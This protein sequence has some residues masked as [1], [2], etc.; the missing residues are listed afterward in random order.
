VTVTPDA[1]A[2]KPGAPRATILLALLAVY[3]IWGSTYLGL[4]YVVEE[5]PPLLSAAARFL[6]AG[7]IMLLVCLLLKKPM[8]TRREWAWSLVIGTLMGLC[9]NGF[10]AI[11][12]KDISSGGAAVVCASMP[13]FA[14][15]LGAFLGAK[16]TRREVVGL[17]IGFIG[18]A[19]MC[20][21]GLSGPPLS[22]ALLLSAPSCWALGSLLAKKHFRSGT[23]TAGAQLLSG[24]GMLAVVGALH[25]EQWPE[26][27][28]ARA[29]WALVYL[30][31]VGSLVGFTAYAY[32]L[33]HTRAAVAMSYAY[34]N[35][36]IALLLGVLLKGETVGI[37]TAIGCA[38]ILAGVVL[39]VTK[40]PTVMVAPVAV[41]KV[42]PADQ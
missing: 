2:Q 28:S 10:V 25:G 13:L 20:A 31:V 32:L 17:A 30:V 42:V 7:G 24:G 39:V 4:R 12:E 37:S 16:P 3:T 9:G 19:V 8:P 23:S 40:P 41:A 1:T 34:V 35:P 15:V 18:V 26:H 21:R 33:Q 38:L 29:A 6:V 5:L 22:L 36:V 27:T 14:A 11:A